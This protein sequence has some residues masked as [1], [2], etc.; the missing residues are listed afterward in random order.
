MQ[1]T[2]V[3]VVG[4][5][6]A[7]VSAAYSLARH[8]AE[9]TVLEKED[10]LTAHSTGRSAAQYLET[11]GG[12][13]NQELTVASR[14]FLVGDAAGFSDGPLLRRRPVLWVGREAG[15]ADLE[16]RRAEASAHTAGLRMLDV[17]EARRLCS[18]LDPAWVGGALLEPDAYD[19][20]VAG[21]H[22][23]FLRGARD[24]AATVVRSAG[25][26]AVSR[27]RGNWAVRTASE[28]YSAPVLVNAAGA[29]ADGVA[30]DAGVDA[31]GLTPLR[32]T[33]F[34]FAAP[35]GCPAAEVE[36]WPLVIDVGGGFYFKPEG[37]GQLL[38]SPHDEIPDEPGDARAQEIDVARGIDAVNAATTFGIRAVRSVWA[39]LRTFAP[40]RHPV[41]GFDDS[42]EGFV[43]CAGQGGTGIQTSPAIGEIVAS[44]VCGTPPPPQLA[45]M[46]ES[47]SPRRL[48]RPG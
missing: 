11:Y 35:A 20:D 8:G 32:R 48:R 17:A 10:S 47:L 43:W 18:L 31:V 25:V 36:R 39:G 27:T 16:K 13:L 38:G 9:V 23:A 28:T 7:G 5:G 40:D 44:V 42:V 14:A 24:G 1:A 22:Q 6:I 30:A 41:V 12:P 3:I 34:T 37:P 19:I 26:A 15:L 46:I 21:L 45:R 29:W 4:G 2:D 33:I